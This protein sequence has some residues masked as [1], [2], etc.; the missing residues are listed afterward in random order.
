MRD[1][2]IRSGSLACA[3][4]VVLPLLMRPGSTAVASQ[5]DATPPP[6]PQEHV[7][8]IAQEVL[9]A[10]AEMNACLMGHG[11]TSTEVDQVL[12][13]AGLGA[14]EASSVPT[15]TVNAMIEL[16]E[17][18][19]V[20]VLGFGF[21]P[22]VLASPDEEPAPAAEDTTALDNAGPESVAIQQAAVSC[23]AMNPAP[24]QGVVELSQVAAAVEE[25]MQTD[26]NVARLRAEWAECV[27]TQ[28]INASS[29]AQLLEATALATQTM[30]E[31]HPMPVDV[32]L[33]RATV[34][35][36]GDPRALAADLYG[37]A[38]T[39]EE[40]ADLEIQV[41][42]AEYDCRAGLDVDR[43]LEQARS[44]IMATRMRE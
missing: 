27:S 23:G 11:P 32:A 43:R 21:A 37:A 19:R 24:P 13:L 6:V 30:R 12:T 31:I 44:A 20:R 35:V 42:Q 10:R 34:D 2:R 15:S 5:P 4:V 28:G 16:P 26:S 25:A 33:A 14:T 8:R 3:M 18:A 1:T 36:V 7:D 41:A 39:W 22:F 40:L 29:Q 9:A 38:E 17:A